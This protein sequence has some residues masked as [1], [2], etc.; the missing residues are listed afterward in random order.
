[1]KELKA[2]VG[3]ARK[4]GLSDEDILHADICGRVPDEITEESLDELTGMLAEV[5]QGS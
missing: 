5:I 4:F 2:R 3:A 1:V